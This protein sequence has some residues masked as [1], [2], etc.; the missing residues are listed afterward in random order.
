M[1]DLGN[2]RIYRK[3]L[4]VLADG[5][6]HM[7]VPEGTEGA[8]KR[9]YETSDK[10]AGFKWELT[11]DK[12]IGVITQI[13]FFEGNF[14]NTLHVVFDD[15]IELSLNVASPYAEDFMKKLPNIDLGASVIIKPYSFEDDKTGKPRKGLSIIQN[16]VKITNHFYDA[17]ARE[18]VNG[19]P[20]PK[21]NTKKYKTDDWKLYFMMARK[22]LV[23]N[24]EKYV[25]KKSE[26]GEVSESEAPALEETE[27]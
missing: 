2:D 20:E 10:V 1:A 23:E 18:N 4:S 16:D 3:Y 11:F 13:F 5:K 27:A 6:L 21:G 8:V 17:E 19:Y 24:T 12:L 22:F 26:V 15:E 25:T 14:G 9:E 7:T